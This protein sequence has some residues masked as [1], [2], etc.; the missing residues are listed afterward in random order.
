[1]R[2]QRD[3]RRAAP[4]SGGTPA[5]PSTEVSRVLELQLT[6]VRSSNL[7]QGGC[8]PDGYLCERAAN[9]VPP[10]G[11][12]YTYG[13]PSSHYLCPSSASYGCCPSGMG[14]AVDQC[15]STDPT[16]VTKTMVITSTA[17]GSAIVYTTTATTVSSPLPPTA[18]PTLDSGDGAQK[19]LKYFPSAIPK[20][21]P[22]SEPGG[23]GGVG[24]RISA[25]QLGGIVAGSASFV[26]IALVAAFLVF[27]R[28]C[29]RRCRSSITINGSKSSRRTDDMKARAQMI[30]VHAL[31]SDADTRSAT[32]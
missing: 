13:C 4:R 2:P 14:C 24:G 23:G 28:F 6:I 8:C 25:A 9:C 1:M 15:Y 20:S 32:P 22:T 17:S 7:A 31:D 26:V 30:Q 11:S 12:P 18:F 21:S 5:R 3:R 19:V 27:R 10:S 16:T 29:A